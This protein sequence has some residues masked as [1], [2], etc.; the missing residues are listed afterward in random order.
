MVGTGPVCE[1]ATAQ[2]GEAGATLAEPRLDAECD[3][4]FVAGKAGV[5][6][7]TAAEA[8][9]ARTIVPAGARPGHGPGAGRAGQADRV[10]IPDFLATAA[11]CWPPTARPD[12]GDPVDR[13]HAA[14]TDLADQG[15]G[16]WLAA[17]LRAEENLA[18]LDRREAVRPPPGLRPGG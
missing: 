16:L 4:L 18:D 14:V 7:H 6:D 17:A 13:I 3:V 15:T 11:P 2:L 9:Q 12:G 1:A 8:V 5:L 10:V